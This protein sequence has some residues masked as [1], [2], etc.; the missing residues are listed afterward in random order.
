MG[1]KKEDKLIEGEM[2]WVEV[3]NNVITLV[4]MDGK[5]MELFSCIDENDSSMFQDTSENSSFTKTFKQ[6][7]TKSQIHEQV[8]EHTHTIVI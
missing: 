4:V 7:K 1:T 3:N 6:F 8:I 5:K 2:S